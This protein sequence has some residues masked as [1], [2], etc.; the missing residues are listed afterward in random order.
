MKK[1]EVKNIDLFTVINDD[2]HHDDHANG[3]HDQ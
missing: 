3:L 2:I 1:S